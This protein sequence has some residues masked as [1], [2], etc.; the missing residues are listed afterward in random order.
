MAMENETTNPNSSPQD[1]L[2]NL[3]QSASMS[4]DLRIG[5]MVALV[6]LDMA[7]DECTIIHHATSR[8]L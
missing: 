8:Q 4:P 3:A 1:I 2:N 6:E 5:A 7:F